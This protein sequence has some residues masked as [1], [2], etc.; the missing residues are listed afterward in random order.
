MDIDIIKCYPS[1]MMALAR[2]HGMD[3]SHTLRLSS[4]VS[5]P[6]AIAEVVCAEV[7]CEVGAVKA[8]VN[9]VISDT[10]LR[11]DRDGVGWM[12]GFEEAVWQLR[13]ELI[14]RHPFRDAYWSQPRSDGSVPNVGTVMYRVLT[15][16][17]VRVVAAAAAELREW[18]IRAATYGYD[19]MRVSADDR[20]TLF[21]AC[22]DDA[23]S[24]VSLAHLA[25]I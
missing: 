9:T 13:T 25:D 23:L 19:G 16:V 11:Y 2:M 3:D 21:H 6:S 15:D 24:A 22:Q 14:S 18:G 12:R 10:A 7:G 1:I 8:M 4:F 5:D 17:E 20:Q